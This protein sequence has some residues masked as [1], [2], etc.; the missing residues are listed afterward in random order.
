[1]GNVKGLSKENMPR[2]GDVM[3]KVGDDTVF[4]VGSFTAAVQVLDHPGDLKP[5]YTPIGFVRTG[6]SAIRMVEI[7]W[8]IGKSTGGAKAEAPATIKANSARASAVSPSWKETVL[9]C[10]ARLTRWRRRL[11]KANRLFVCD[12]VNACPRVKRLA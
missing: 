9:S 4:T 8:K 2:V 6:R 10:L 12:V 3:L 11:R 7:K 1:M 5:G